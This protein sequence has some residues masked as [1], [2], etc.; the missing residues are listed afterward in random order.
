MIAPVSTVMSPLGALRFRMPCVCA[1]LDQGV[2]FSVTPLRTVMSPVLQAT[3]PKSM[4]VAPAQVICGAVGQ[5]Q[6]PVA[7]HCAGAP[8]LSVKSSE[9]AKAGGARETAAAARASERCREIIDAS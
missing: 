8:P 2:T 7:M 4:H 9:S 6:A 5:A 3:L 1:A